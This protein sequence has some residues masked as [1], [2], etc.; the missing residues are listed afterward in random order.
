ME[1]VIDFS[2]EVFTSV[3][4]HYMQGFPEV[5]S[6]MPQNSLNRP[7]DGEQNEDDVY[8][9]RFELEFEEWT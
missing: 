3:S 5:A 6:S 2:G 4:D 9:R 1:G 7:S 8:H